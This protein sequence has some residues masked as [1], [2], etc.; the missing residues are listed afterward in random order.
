MHITICGMRKW[1]FKVKRKKIEVLCVASCSVLVDMVWF[2]L[3][4]VPQTL[5]IQHS[6][7][8]GGRRFIS[9]F[10]CQVK[11]WLIS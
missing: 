3:C 10:V 1:E 5:N 11:S 7:H 6:A 8:Q 4:D 9:S 2:L